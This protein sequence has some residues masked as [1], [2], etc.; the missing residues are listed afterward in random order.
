MCYPLGGWPLGVRDCGV[1]EPCSR[2]LRRQHGWPLHTACAR[3]TGNGVLLSAAHVVVALPRVI[4]MIRYAVR[5]I[6][7]ESLAC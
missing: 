1:R 3:C 7:Y 6:V 5:A 2:F 4:C